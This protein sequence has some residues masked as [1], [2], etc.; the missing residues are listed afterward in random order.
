LLSGTKR[1]ASRSVLIAD[2]ETA[3]ASTDV[4]SQISAL[5]AEIAT[6]Q[7][8]L[9][10]RGSEAYETI[11]DRAGNAVDAARPAVRSATKYVRS[12]GA[13]VAQAAREHPAGLS[14]VVLTAG[15]AG[16]VLGY[17]LGS[18]E[19]EPPRRQRWF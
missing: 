6:L 18:L 1:L 7:K 2:K 3:M 16:V 19:N 10:D 5:R 11:R 14:T 15:L 17:L 9:S 12:E 4:Q 8:D 13:A